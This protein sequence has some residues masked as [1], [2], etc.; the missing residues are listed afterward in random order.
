MNAE[1]IAT[2]G[3]IAMRSS[4]KIGSASVVAMALGAPA[5]AEVVC[6]EDGVFRRV[7]QRYEYR[8]EVKLRVYPD[9][10]K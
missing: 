8:P 10:W 7:K 3:A 1:K 6:N 2:N 4:A 9:N 5:R